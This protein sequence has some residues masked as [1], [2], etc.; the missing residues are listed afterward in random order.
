MPRKLLD[1]DGNEVE[2]PDD[3]ELEALRADAAKKAELEAENEKLKNDP[4]K[5][6]WRKA[7]AKLKEAGKDFNEEGEV[8]ENAKPM[9]AEEVAQ[10]STQS[11]NNAVFET[12]KDKIRLAMPEKDRE[13][14][15]Y[16][17]NKFMTGEEKSIT[18]LMKFSEEAKNNVYPASSPDRMNQAINSRGGQGGIKKDDKISDTAKEIGSAMGN[19]EKDLE[20][21]SD[22]IKF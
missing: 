5:I 14:F 10:I 15:D 11:V 12:E 16:Y 1:A 21:A 19:S 2:V 20:E 7:R 17:F 6:N 22:T 13:L 3:T 18:N 9:T 8:I 4:E